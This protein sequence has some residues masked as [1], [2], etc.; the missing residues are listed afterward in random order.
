[1]LIYE[2]RNGILG[3]DSE[4]GVIKLGDDLFSVT[5]ELK[6]L[7]ASLSFV[8]L[9]I[10][11]NFSTCYQELFASGSFTYISNKKMQWNSLLEQKLK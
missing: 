7:K 3:F 5:R 2:R 1:M 9:L 10:C 6:S 4:K 8:V 11:Y